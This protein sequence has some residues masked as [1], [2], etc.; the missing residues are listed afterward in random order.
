VIRDLGEIQRDHAGKEEAHLVE[1][2]G[3]L[4]SI[5]EAEEEKI[6]QTCGLIILGN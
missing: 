5:P 3:R 4:T 6:V 1:G 2:K